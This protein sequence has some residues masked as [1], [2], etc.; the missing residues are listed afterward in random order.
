MDVFEK[1]WR[2]RFEDG[3]IDEEH[4]LNDIQHHHSHHHGFGSLQ[5]QQALEDE[6][7][8]GVCPPMVIFY[9]L[10]GLGGEATEEEV[11][12]LKE[13]EEEEVNP[14]EEFKCLRVLDKCDG[15]RII[16]NA[17]GNLGDIEKDPVE[18][19]LLSLLIKT[20]EY[21]CKLKKHRQA[22]LKAHDAVGVLFPITVLLLQYQE[23]DLLKITSKSLH[24]LHVILS[25]TT[26][27]TASRI[28]TV[29][30]MHELLKC[31]GYGHIRSDGNR[32]E[33][34]I[35]TAICQLLP[36]LTNDE[37]E[38]A[39]T[40]LEFFSEYLPFGSEQDD[41]Q[42]DEHHIGCLITMCNV[43]AQEEHLRRFQKLREVALDEGLIVSCLNHIMD[44]FGHLTKKK[45]NREISQVLSV[46]KMLPLILPVLNGLVRGHRSSQN[47]A[48]QLKVIPI[49]HSMENAATTNAVGPLAESLLE[50]LAKNNK[51]ITNKI[52]KLRNK[53]TD[54]KKK[55]QMK[56][57]KK[58]LEQ[59]NRS[60]MK[61]SQ[62]NEAED[63]IMEELEDEPSQKIRC[64][65]CKEGYH[66]KKHDIMGIYVNN[67]DLQTNGISLTQFGKSNSD[68]LENDQFSTATMCCF[69]VIH[70]SC[71]R[72]AVR[73]DHAAKKQKKEW[74]GAKLRNSGVATN[75]ILPI[76]T[77]NRE[78]GDTM[79]YE[80]QQR[81][82]EYWGRIAENFGSAG[83]GVPILELLIE[84]LRHC[85]GRYAFEESFSAETGGGGG[86]LSNLLFIPFMVQAAIFQYR[87][88]PSSNS[89]NVFKCYQQRLQFEEPS[90]AKLLHYREV[91]QNPDNTD[92][93]META[94]SVLEAMEYVAT[95][96]LIFTKD[97]GEWNTI[98]QGV[99]VKLM[100]H[101]FLERDIAECAQDFGYDAE[102]KE[103]KEQKENKEEEG[104][105]EHDV[106]NE[107]EEEEDED[108]DEDEDEDEDEDDDENGDGMNESAQPQKPDLKRKC[109]CSER[110]VLYKGNGK[111]EEETV[112]CSHCRSYLC[113]PQKVIWDCPSCCFR[114]CDDCF[115]EQRVPLSL[116]GVLSLEAYR[117]TVMV[118]V[119]PIFLLSIFI[120]ELHSIIK[121]SEEHLQY[122]VDQILTELES[123]LDT[124][125]REWMQMTTFSEFE[126][127]L[128]THGLV[129][130]TMA[131]SGGNKPGEDAND[132]VSDMRWVEQICGFRP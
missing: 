46:N 32:Q 70:F 103:E 81:L 127:T 88:A 39:R 98:K 15:L 40:V 77:T 84:D 66:L 63:V 82:K 90:L 67:K 10:R 44:H 72:A 125:D 129:P 102:E 75:N 65:V 78:S 104:A 93:N 51:K 27:C 34:G 87:T 89:Q 2:R 56:F 8:E 42:I 132:S 110:L 73:A 92:A 45:K 6:Y 124:F 28:I 96:S 22:L 106:D 91:N 3:E 48:F 50:G 29:S 95:Q 20:M 55:K 41:S 61:K 38:L 76:K 19:Q 97:V 31:L 112:E 60:K 99:F 64:M 68:D 79:D 128:R 30:Q 1:F 94:E 52:A 111:D 86:K 74:E 120:D 23:E 131:I 9:R 108:A 109:P 121:K 16:L 59:M 4:V 26:E 54:K 7:D 24:L 17:F 35:S 49:L 114:I 122:E 115:C 21:C 118:I 43:L 47:L 69:N 33:S 58:M 13:D 119:K 14:E 105:A 71:H 116:I 130:P 25:E 5:Q 18:R 62:E 101:A 123:M 80:Y 57:R 53:T 36:F 12:E 107:Q 126:L 113:F 11:N 85:I 37:T 117:Q 83:Y 100:K